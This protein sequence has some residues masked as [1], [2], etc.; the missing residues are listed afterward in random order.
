MAGFHPPGQPLN[1]SNVQRGLVVK[2]PERCAW[3]GDV[4]ISW[5]RVPVNCDGVWLLEAA[6]KMCLSRSLTVVW[7]HVSDGGGARMEVVSYSSQQG[8]C[9]PFR[10]WRKW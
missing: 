1:Y 2:P 9:L 7:F 5:R 10:R 6:G 4:A 3:E 8:E